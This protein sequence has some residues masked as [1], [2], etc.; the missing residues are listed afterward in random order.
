MESW[1]YFTGLK[2]IWR[3]AN[4]GGGRRVDG[5]V[6]GW[7][8]RLSCRLLTWNRSSNVTRRVDTK[9]SDRWIRNWRAQDIFIVLL[10]LFYNTEWHEMFHWWEAGKLGLKYWI[11]STR[12]RNSCWSLM[13]P[14]DS[15]SCKV[16]WVNSES[17]QNKSLNKKRVKL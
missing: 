16:W 14:C 5:R 13:P 11:P 7:T 17:L 9:G 6:A 10:R 15:G 4:P 1:L 2:R 3:F 12:L 8:Q